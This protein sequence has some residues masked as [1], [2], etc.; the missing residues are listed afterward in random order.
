MSKRSNPTL[1]GAFVL[2]A[3]LLL[4]TAVLLF[5]GAQLFA[6]KRV[7]VS[8]FPDSVKGLREG[9]SVVLNGVPI[10]FVKGIRL[11]GEVRPNDAINML[12]EVTME[13]L[14]EHYELFVN[15]AT[16]GNDARSRLTP[17]E[18]VKAGIRAKLVTDSFVTGQLLVEL[19]FEPEIPAVFRATKKGPPEIPTIPS[20]VQQVVERVQD[21][22]AKI[23][24]DVDVEQFSKN[25]QGIVSGMNE[26]AN[27]PDLRAALA[28]ASRLT[29]D[30]IPRLTS[31]IEKSLAD[32]RGATK[33]AR[34]LVQ[35]VDKRLDPLMADLL[36]AVARLDGTLKGAEQVLK[37]LAGNLRED[38]E[39][40]LEVRTTLQDLQA[41]SD[42]ATVL[43][44]YLD[45]HPEALLRGKSE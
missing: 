2:G 24:K 29:N 27:S 36:P 45:E 3:V 8:Y 20:D 34:L 39:L 17:N 13:V 40:A 11:S 37:L 6:T 30:D 10:G 15:G 9:S 32:L 26:L 28:G 5:G 7:L 23:S 14:P 44:E 25:I 19:V 41:A 38:S 16:L 31:S 12:V 18:F 21:F 22:F 43:L 33:D 1:I 35:H 4:V 42:A